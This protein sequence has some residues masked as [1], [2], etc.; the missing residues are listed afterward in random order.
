MEVQPHPE[1]L[2]LLRVVAPEYGAAF[3]VSGNCPVQGSGAVGGRDLYF[4]ARHGGW[5]FD[6]ADDRGT[7]PS[8]GGDLDAGGFYREADYPDASRMPHARAVEIIAG[9]LREYIGSRP[10]QALQRTPGA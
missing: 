7:L 10:N 1:G 4:R 2:E 5:S 8:D 9:C 3:E 6:I